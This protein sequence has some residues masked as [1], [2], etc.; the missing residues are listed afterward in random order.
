MQTNKELAIEEAGRIWRATVG[1]LANMKKRIRAEAEAQ[2]EAETLRR[3]REAACAIHIALEAGASKAS[4]RKVTTKDHWGF[5]SYVELGE[6]LNL[7]D[8]A[9]VQRLRPA[10]AMT[11][12]AGAE[13][14]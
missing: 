3:Q 4:I 1:D 5:E 2:I 10:R 12:S 14:R 6:H 9:D 11:N 13:G 8:P 7:M